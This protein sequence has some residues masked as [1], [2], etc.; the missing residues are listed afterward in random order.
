MNKILN[1]DKAFWVLV[2]AIVVTYF[3]SALPF[4]TNFTT[5]LYDDPVLLDPLKKITS[6]SSYIASYMN[7]EIWDVQPVRDLTYLLDLYLMKY[8]N[9]WNHHI[10][11]FTIWFFIG[12]YGFNVLMQ[13]QRI[14][15][16]SENHQLY[17]N[18]K[19]AFFFILLYI[20]FPT[21]QIG[22]FWVANRK[23]ILAC[24][25]I[26]ISFYY[27]L[28]SYLAN[29][30]TKK[31]I[32][33][34][35]IFYFLSIFSQPITIFYPA[36]VF[37]FFFLLKKKNNILHFL[38]ETLRLWII[39][40]ILSI[41]A[42]ATNY[43]FYYKWYP[44]MTQGAVDF[45]PDNVWQYRLLNLGRFFYQ[46]F[47]FTM[48]MPVEHDAGSVR[49]IIGLLSLPLFFWWA[50]KKVGTK[51][52]LI[53]LAWFLFPISLII[54]KNVKLFGL[55]SYIIVAYFG[56]IATLT[57]IFSHYKFRNIYF[58]LFF[59][60]LYFSMNY[61]KLFKDDLAL[62]KYAYAKEVTMFSQ[63][64]LASA[65]LN[66]GESDQAFQEF[67]ALLKIAPL[68]KELPY[69]LPLSLYDS[70]KIAPKI[71]QNLLFEWSK[72]GFYAHGFYALTYPVG[73]Q[74]FLDNME[75]AMQ[76]VEDSF[77]LPM[78]RFSMRF[79]AL[80]LATCSYENI[81][82]C[83]AR[84]TALK[85]IAPKSYWD[86]ELFK[87]NI[88]EFSKLSFSRQKINETNVLENV[89]GSGINFSRNKKGP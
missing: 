20:V 23:H 40:G 9:F 7:Y 33:L 26:I 89:F 80:Y 87:A 75:R 3:F 55:D 73:S 44:I 12:I 30:L 49:N 84:I 11:N 85:K 15:I 88:D 86:D 79:F 61:S 5:I 18:S 42:A 45:V 24:L 6:L 38:K 62:A 17:D 83:Q 39:L 66:R 54:I 25:F 68:Y 74:R 27:V 78:P 37:I 71:K 31:S 82:K 58:V 77:K 14:L 57:L 43:I 2:A 70:K 59:P 51:F 46:S 81:K 4:L 50:M 19:W 36:F 53:C 32:S 60:I 76:K 21:M 65:L 56:I 67:Y 52:M 64:A 48:A 72:N 1:Q 47:D 22:P 34:I 13:M 41:I 10:L 28:N 8:L 16:V 35:C 63:Y 69:V 29:G